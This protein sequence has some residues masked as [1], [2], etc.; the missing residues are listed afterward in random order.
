MSMA[1][2]SSSVS[3]QLQNANGSAKQTNASI[4]FLIFSLFLLFQT[5]KI[6]FF[7]LIT[8]FLSNF[9]TGLQSDEQSHKVFSEVLLRLY[10]P[11]IGRD[12]HLVH[13]SKF[14]LSGFDDN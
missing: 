12:S 7:R 3:S 4:N 1:P 8:K 10:V 9:A 13:L 14:V 11:D 2:M 6:C 5:A